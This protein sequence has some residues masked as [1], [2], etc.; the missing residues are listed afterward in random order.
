MVKKIISK[1]YKR[2]NCSVSTV[3]QKTDYRGILRDKFSSQKNKTVMVKPL[4]IADVVH[5]Y[6]PSAL[7]ELIGTHKIVQSKKVILEKEKSVRKRRFMN[8]VLGIT[9]A[10]LIGIAQQ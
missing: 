7:D 8:V 10:D 1:T 6:N 3:S 5:V 2:V 4:E 9:S